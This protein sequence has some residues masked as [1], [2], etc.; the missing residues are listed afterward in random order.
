MN[1]NL[2]IDGSYLLYKDV[3]ILHKNKLLKDQL[4][5][6]L[7]NDFKKITKSYH[8]NQICFVSDSSKSWRFDIFKDYKG[9]RERDTDIDWD[10]VFDTYKNFKNIIKNQK[11]VKFFELNSIEGDDFIAHIIRESNLEGISNIIV[12]SDTDLNQL[13]EYNNEKKYINI[14]WNYKFSDEVV[15]IPKNYQLFFNHINENIVDDMFN[16]S[17]DG[18]IITWIETLLNRVHLKEI[19]S[20]EHLFKKLITGD[21]GDNIPALIKLKSG[22]IDNVNGQAIANTGAQTVY[23]YY[24]EIY[25]NDIDFKSNLFLE[26]IA[27]VIAYYKKLSDND[28][29]EVIKKNMAFNLK[30]I[31]LD[32]DYMPLGV[33]KKMNDYYLTEIV[34]ENDILMEDLDE[35]FKQEGFIKPAY[36]YKIPE[37]FDKI[38]ISEEFSVDDF[39]EL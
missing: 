39:F 16:P 18:E 27:D 33:Y 37:K 11:N 10:F 1:I 7:Y 5:E 9:T 35:R 8:F 19:L 21:K 38:N 34:R 36:D 23:N 15:Y 6:L 29:K 4:K 20:E 2:I 32:K 26:R 25:P 14:Q 3:F 24:K 13:L 31:K 30:M 22:K 28:I 12:S 17:D